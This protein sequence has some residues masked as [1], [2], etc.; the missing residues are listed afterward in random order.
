MRGSD[1]IFDIPNLCLLISGVILLLIRLVVSIA[2]F[3]FSICECLS[4]TG[5]RAIRYY[6]ELDKDYIREIVANDMDKKAVDCI[7][8]NIEKNGISQSFDNFKVLQSIVF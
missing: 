8:N 6:L 3:K 2:L 4:A 1:T 5:L 7:Y